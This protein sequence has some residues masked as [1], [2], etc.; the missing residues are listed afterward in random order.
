[1]GSVFCVGGTAL[2]FKREMEVNGGVT[3]W[4]EQPAYPPFPGS[5]EGRR[6][7]WWNSLFG[8]AVLNT[9]RSYNHP[10]SQHLTAFTANALSS[11]LTQDLQQNGLTHTHK[12]MHT[13]TPL[14]T[15]TQ[16]LTQKRFLHT[17]RPIKQTNVSRSFWN[18]SNSES[19]ITLAFI[20]GNKSVKMHSQPSLNHTHILS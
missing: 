3:V 12:N 14:R 13:Q 8:L 9:F 4:A 19:T 17:D 11:F 6:P 15:H 1:M 10:A 7:E 2:L 5:S 16:T 18:Q 20:L